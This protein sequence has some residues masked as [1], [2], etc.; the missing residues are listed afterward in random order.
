MTYHLNINI[1]QGKRIQFHKL[2]S[3][4]SNFQTCPPVWVDGFQ[5]SNLIYLSTI[6]LFFCNY[7]NYS[8]YQKSGKYLHNIL[9]KQKKILKKG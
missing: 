8:I 7:L 6:T 4:F 2:F 5:I 9:N 3:F 1:Q